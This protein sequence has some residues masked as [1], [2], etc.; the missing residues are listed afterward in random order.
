MTRIL[1]T[2]VAL[3]LGISLPVAAQSP[4]QR[5]YADTMKA[6]TAAYNKGDYPAAIDAYIIAIQ[7]GPAE[8]SAYRNLARS[9]FWAGDYAGAVAAYDNYFRVDPMGGDEKLK[10]ERRLAA[11]RAGNRVYTPPAMQGQALAALQGA[12][13]RGRAYTDGGGGAYGLY[14]TLLRTRYAEPSL[15]QVRARLARRLLD[16]FDAELLTGNAAVT[17]R[18]DLEAWELQAQRLSAA[19]NVADDSVVLDIA[20]QRSVVVEAATAMLTSRWPAAVELA[21]TARQLNPDLRFLW[22]FEA[23]SLVGAQRSQDAEAVIEELEATLSAD[24]V[25]NEMRAYARILRAVAMQHDGRDA[26]AATLFLDVLRQN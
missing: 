13:E 19:R 5:Q 4:S 14:Q 8:S 21:R 20:E 7:S 16:E 17:P 25:D 26:D 12:L 22:W 23:C 18:L 3:I 15:T 24:A 2:V 11:E 1:F 6:G 9:R 10:A